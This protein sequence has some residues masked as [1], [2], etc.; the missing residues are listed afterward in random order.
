M[1]SIV[2]I[3]VLPKSQK[4]PAGDIALLE[5]VE[6]GGMKQWI[7]ANGE[8]EDLPLLLWLHGG[9]GAAQMPVARYF[10]RN[11]EQ[12]FIV[13][14]W[15]Q[16]GAGKSNPKD[17]DE[18]TMSIERFVEDIHEMTAY[19]KERFQKDKLYLLGHSW[20]SQIGIVAAN[21]YS[22]DYIAYIGVSQ[23]T[24][25]NESNI[26]AHDELEKRIKEKGREKAI[27]KVALLNGP[28][29]KIHSEYVAFAKLMDE[30]NMNTDVKMSKF[31]RIALG[32]DVYSIKDYWFWI[33]GANRGSG[34]MWEETQEWD[35]L[36]W[37]PRVDIPSFFII[38]EN[39]FNTPFILMETVMKEL[40][41]PEGK[42]L[43][44]FE[45]AAHM[46]FFADPERFLHE[47]KKIKAFE[48]NILNF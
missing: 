24:N 34:P 23:L 28:P 37:A 12:E 32:S 7:M 30:Y 2:I 45:N 10:N 46:P 15:D 29:Y 42:E 6:I 25:L 40:Q 27:K 20:G 22:D 4:Y 44:I 13:V 33:K 8:S 36:E 18:S 26:I 19:L 5:E 11:L 21:R 16:R 39:D 9:P 41:A 1:I 43:I 14:H 31:I 17:F 3:L 38:G 35:L 47:L 48:K